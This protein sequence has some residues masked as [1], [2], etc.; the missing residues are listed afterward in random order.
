[1]AKAA[2]VDE[3][4]TLPATLAALGACVVAVAWLLWNERRPRE[5]GKVRLIPPILPL[6]IAFFAM[7]VL[8]ARALSLIGVPTHEM[9]GY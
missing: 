6:F 7:I 8:A 9:L 3:L 2:D 4:L 1:L 5:F